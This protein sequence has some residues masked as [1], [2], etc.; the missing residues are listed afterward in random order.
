MA[1]VT[2]YRCARSEGSHKYQLP[3][4]FLSLAISIP[5]DRCRDLLSIEQ[6]ELLGLLQRFQP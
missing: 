2:Y 3:L 6:F 1:K 4:L 5:L